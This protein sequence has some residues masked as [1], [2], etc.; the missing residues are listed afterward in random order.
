MNAPY[1]QEP[2][3]CDYCGAP[4]QLANAEFEEFPLPISSGNPYPGEIYTCKQPECVE[5]G[6]SEIIHI[7]KEVSDSLKE[8]EE[9][10]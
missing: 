9:E 3:K 4:L 1:Q 6:R 2:G 10:D 7:W 8:E 5:K